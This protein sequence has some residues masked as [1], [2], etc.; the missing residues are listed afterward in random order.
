MHIAQCK[1]AIDLTFFCVDP[2]MIEIDGQ[3]V[4]YW[5]SFFPSDVSCLSLINTP[6]RTRSRETFS[7][8]WII[9]IQVSASSFNVDFF[10]SHLMMCLVCASWGTTTGWPNASTQKDVYLPSFAG[11]AGWVQDA[12]WDRIPSIKCTIPFIRQWRIPSTSTRQEDVYLPSFAGNAGW[13]HDAERDRI[14]SNH[15]DNPRCTMIIMNRMKS[16]SCTLLIKKWK[17]RLWKE[18]DA[19]RSKREEEVILTN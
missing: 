8:F 13:V 15:P 16:S 14:R 4:R 7:L 17:R 12:E 6:Q 11:N 9:E 10:V 19:V 3:L 1:A 2:L 18:T 5:F